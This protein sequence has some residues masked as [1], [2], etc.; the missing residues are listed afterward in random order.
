M[1]RLMT[2]FTAVALLSSA[3]IACDK[4]GATEQQKEINANEQAA[5]A[6]AEA[7][8]NALNA[9]AQSERKIA[10][11]R[12]DFEKERDDYQH[13]RQQ[14]VADVNKKIA[15][16]EAK[17]KTA[18]GKEK[19]KLDAN[20]PN[21]R[22]RRDQFVIDMQRLDQTTPASWDGAKAS[23][24]KEWDSLKSAIDQSY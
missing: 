3:I 22:A 8:R 24:D 11:A 15:D 1:K 6:K 9:Q 23:L 5:Q 18:T 19:A 20:M 12:A 21:L 16:L 10:G 13:S 2:S 14:D 17:H 4:P 7:D